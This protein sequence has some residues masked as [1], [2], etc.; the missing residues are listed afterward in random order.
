MKSLVKLLVIGSMLALFA[1][2]AL[3]DGPVLQLGI[4]DGVYDPVTETV[5]ASSNPFTLYAFLNDSTLLGETFYI[6][7]AVTPQYGPTGGDLGSF[8]FDGETIDVTADM[9]YGTPPIE[10]APLNVFEAGDLSKHGIFNT[11]YREFDFTFNTSSQTD[12]FNVQDN[13]GMVPTAGS[14]MYYV[15]FN[16]DTSGLDYPYAI[17]FDLYSKSADGTSI[18]IFAPFSHDAQ[19]PVPEPGT[20][21]LLGTGI[22]AIGAAFKL[23]KNKK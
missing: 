23:R 11:Y 18:G 19:S 8:T 9:T 3:A 10:L 22:L 20:L 6:S 13:P 5:I 2:I 1:N 12:S 4:G 15:A 14:G 17:H 7:A 16:V 21:T